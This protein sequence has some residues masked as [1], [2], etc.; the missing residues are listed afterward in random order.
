MYIYV[1]VNDVIT[2]NIHADIVPED[3]QTSGPQV[4]SPSG[5][6]RQHSPVESWQR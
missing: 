2:Y 5:R 3:L 4:V 6:A 1:H